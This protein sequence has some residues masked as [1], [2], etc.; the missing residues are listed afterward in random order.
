M[1]GS[2]LQKKLRV[3]PGQ[4]IL[5]ANPPEGF[6]E[7]LGE[8]PEGCKLST[9]ARGRFDHVHLFAADPSTAFRE[10]GEAP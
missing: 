1:A 3:L 7:A 6:I 8:L 2:G 10:K 4:R 9:A 5:V